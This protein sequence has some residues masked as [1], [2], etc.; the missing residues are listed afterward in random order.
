M[1]RYDD[2]LRLTAPGASRSVWRLPDWFYPSGGR[3]PL[4]SHARNL[5]RWSRTE[6]GTLLRSVPR[7]QEFV[8]DGDFYPEAEPWA[9]GLIAAALR[10]S[11]DSV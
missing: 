4:G 8:L 7:G 6:D 1:P 10:P 11:T 3:P 5:E 9:R 2:R